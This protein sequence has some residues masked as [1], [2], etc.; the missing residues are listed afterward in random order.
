MSN[1]RKKFR[2]A[3][4]ASDR[5]VWLSSRFD[6]H[7]LSRLNSCRSVIFLQMPGN[8]TGDK[9]KN[10]RLPHSLAGTRL[11]IASAVWKTIFIT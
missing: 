3:Q 1:A 7:A 4:G 8:Q 5:S 11:S 10:V 6:R 2:K 9:R